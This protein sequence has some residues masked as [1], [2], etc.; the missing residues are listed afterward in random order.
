MSGYGEEVHEKRVVCGCGEEGGVWM[1]GG[2]KVCMWGGGRVCRKGER[3]VDVGKEDQSK[4]NEY[5][6]HKKINHHSNT[7]CAWVPS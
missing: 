6:G 1:W 2:E 3:C 5:R 7:D 4:Q